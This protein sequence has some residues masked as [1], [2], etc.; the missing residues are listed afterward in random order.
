MIRKLIV[1]ATGILLFSFALQAQLAFDTLLF[2]IPL[3]DDTTVKSLFRCY[4]EGRIRKTISGPVI[5]EGKTLLFYSEEGYLLYD[6]RGTIVDSHSVFK[7]NI[8]LPKKSTKKIKFAFPT[9]NETLLYYQKINNRESPLTLIEKKLYKK[10]LRPLREKEYKFYLEAGNRHLFN[11]AHNSITD[12]MAYT[13]FVEP[14][15]IGFTALTAGDKWWSVDKFYTFSSPI[16]NEKDGKY[17]SFF[18]GIRPRNSRDKQQLVNPI[19]VFKWDRNWYYAGVHANVGTVEERYI[20][21]FYICDPAGNILYSDDLLKLT[22]RDAIIGEDDETYYTV[23]KIERFVFQPSVDNDGNVYYGIIDYVKNDIEVRERGYFRYTKVSSEPDLAHLIDV[24]K[25]ITY[26]PV[27]IPCNMK[28]PGGK[29]IPDVT[30]QNAKGVRI[31]A[32]AKH[33]TKSEYVIRISRVI[34]RDVDKKLAR[35][36]RSLPEKVQSIKDSLSGLSSISCPY[37][38]TLSGPKGMIRSFNYPSGMD[39]LCARVLAVRKNSDVV[40]RIDCETFAEILIFKTDGSFANRFLFNTQDYKK[41]KDVVVATDRSPI[42]EL[43]YES[44]KDEGKF[45]R[46]EKVASK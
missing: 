3:I 44:D 20:Q 42:I 16:I 5:M 35:G 32:K 8:G 43:D 23:K 22:N 36:R 30:L 33:L 2:R 18:P 24:E 31:K 10:R 19:Q 25:N 28:Q 38:V 26:K 6:R 4:G 11:I 29:S 9:N 14:Q 45:F 37:T 15:L 7:K 21:T 40:V 46:W 41:R 34:Y 17:H 12:D 1:M 13:Y 27:S 39:V